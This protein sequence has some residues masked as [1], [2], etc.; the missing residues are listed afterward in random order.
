MEATK[1]SLIL[2]LGAGQMANTPLPCFQRL[3]ILTRDA[4]KEANLKQKGIQTKL[5][6][7]PAPPLFVVEFQ[8]RGRSSNWGPE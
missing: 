8:F 3:R 2:I 6:L 4:N 7:S 1:D 5:F